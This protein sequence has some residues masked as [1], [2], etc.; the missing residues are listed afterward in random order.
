MV[1]KKNACSEEMLSVEAG[2]ELTESELAA[3]CGGTGGSYNL[4]SL[5]NWFGVPQTQSTSAKGHA[6]KNNDSSSNFNSFE[7]VSNL[8]NTLLGALL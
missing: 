4:P 3:V 2:Y 1:Q 6:A 7:A 5:P 8:T